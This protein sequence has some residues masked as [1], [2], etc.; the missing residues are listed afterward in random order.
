MKCYV[1]YNDLVLSA[2]SAFNNCLCY[3]AYINYIYYLMGFIL[4]YEFLIYLKNIPSSSHVVLRQ[5]RQARG[6]Q[7][8]H[9]TCHMLL[10]YTVLLQIEC[11]QAS[12]NPCL[13]PVNEYD[14]SLRAIYI[15]R[16]F[17]NISYIYISVYLCISVYTCAKSV[18]RISTYL[19]KG[20]YLNK[21]VC[22]WKP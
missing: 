12:H 22:G 3:K 21:A 13:C 2:K 19:N 20:T 7:L 16:I 18:Y 5:F 9:L 10:F 8:S 4:K 17:V 1:Y 6:W 15:L 11:I 14:S